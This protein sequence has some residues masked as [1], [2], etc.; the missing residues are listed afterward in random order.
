MHNGISMTSIQVNGVREEYAS[1]QIYPFCNLVSM[2][3]YKSNRSD[4]HIR[5]KQNYY[6]SKFKVLLHI[7]LSSILH[8]QNSNIRYRFTR[9]VVNSVIS[10]RR[11]LKCVRFRM[12]HPTI[13]TDEFL[14]NGL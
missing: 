13:P 14:I 7:H 10:K 1:T 3:W 12:S 11:D 9:I 2:R 8:I 4:L 6:T 5:S